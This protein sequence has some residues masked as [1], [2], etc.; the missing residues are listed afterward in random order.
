MG[1]LLDDGSLNLALVPPILLVSV[2]SKNASSTYGLDGE[3]VGDNV[4][5]HGGH[6]KR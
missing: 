1:S 2:A 6:A 5:T 3:L 4:F